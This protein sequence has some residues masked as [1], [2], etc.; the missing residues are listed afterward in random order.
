MQKYTITI[1]GIA[2]TVKK[3][4]VSKSMRII[5]H[6]GGQVT[7][8]CPLRARKSDIENFIAL[9]CAWIT[10]MQ[11]KS[12]SLPPESKNLRVPVE[13]LKQQAKTYVPERLLFWAR[14]NGLKYK[15]LTIGSAKTKWGSCSR[16]GRIRISCFVMLLTKEQ[17]D[18]VLLHELCH[19]IHFN[20][21]AAFHERLNQMLP[22]HNEK[23]LV[24][25]I[26]KISIPRRK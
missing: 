22:G 5:V 13:V 19:L 18:Y 25:E 7:A 1:S 20:H 2:V 26:R 12:V 11:K 24:K 4:S 8:T 10:S 16:D 9:N 17:I 3:Y 14:L 21:S 15:T 6:P 23:Q